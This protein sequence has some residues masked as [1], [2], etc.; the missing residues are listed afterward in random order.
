M[1]GKRLALLIANAQYQHPK[2]RQLEAPPHDVR[3]LEK[4]LEDPNI[5]GYEPLVLVDRTK[6]EVERAINRLLASG[7]REDLV[8]IFFAGH[9]LKHEN[10]KLY[11]AMTDTEP[12]FLAG[13]AVS[14]G[15]LVEQM[16]DS[17]I[18]RQIVI[19]D[20]CY[21]GAF[22][23]SLRRSGDGGLAESGKVLEIPDLLENGRGQVV[24]T[25]TD[26]MQFAFED[27]DLKKKPAE[28]HFTRLLIEALSTGDADRNPRDGRITIDKLMRFL[29]EGLARNGSKQ[30]PQEWRFGVS[31]SDLQF[32]S[33]PRAYRGDTSLVGPQIKILPLEE[34]AC[35]LCTLKGHTDRITALSVSPGIALLGTE[36]VDKT[37][38]IAL[39]A[40][41]SRDKTVRLWR[42]S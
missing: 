23:R 24:I 7:K 17:H 25:A 35:L 2:L 34:M 21:G 16:Q 41:G 27:G 3:A 40:S 1:A 28:S 22:G 32:A 13:T 19:L 38:T 6:A 9:G 31:G 39:L 29:K 15:W 11:F 8:L 14:A 36:S 20:C 18:G 5:G 37:V 4:V 30:K 42:V 26:A 33:N 10:G 12:D